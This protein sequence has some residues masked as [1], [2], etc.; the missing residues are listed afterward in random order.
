MNPFDVDTFL[1]TGGLI[2]LCLLV[3][4]ETGLLIGFVFPGD[5]VLFTAGVFA[6]QPDPFAPLWLLCIAVPA[7]A[8]IGDQVGYAIG[9][10]LGSSVVESR[11][12]RLV[13]P[14]PLAKTHRYFE[15]FGALTVFFARFIGIVRTL[16]PLVA[17]FTGMS[18]RIFTLFS[19]LGS[20][21]WAAGII[22]LGYFLGQ[23]SIIR[24]HLDVFI[25]A[26]VL[27]VV[28][29]TAL[30]LA[31]RWRNGRRTSQ[32]GAAEPVP[33]EPNPEPSAE[34]PTS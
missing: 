4:V 12:M 11:L 14:E 1:A 2:G 10:R 30:H 22:T 27:T 8:I 17:G 13:G 23:V 3:F 16:T 32:D 34:K 31:R 6:A 21:A 26:S 15:R 5:S 19:V 29:P 28:V 20:F 24:D 33:E 18:Y 9:R 25:I 7:A